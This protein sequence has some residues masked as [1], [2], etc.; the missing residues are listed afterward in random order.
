MK[1]TFR[2]LLLLAFACLGLASLSSPAQAQQSNPVSCQSL[3]STT[4]AEAFFNVVHLIPGLPLPCEDMEAL[5]QG[6]AVIYST[7]RT[8]ELRAIIAEHG[9]TSDRVRRFVD[10]KLSKEGNTFRIITRMGGHVYEAT[11]T[12]GVDM[13]ANITTINVYIIA[14]DSNGQAVTRHTAQGA[15]WQ[16][17]FSTA[18]ASALG[19]TAVNVATLGTQTALQE[20]TGPDCRGN[21][22]PQQVFH[23]AGGTASSAS[24]SD[25]RSAIASNI[26]NVVEI[27]SACGTG[28]SICGAQ[29]YPS[30]HPVGMAPA[31]DNNMALA[32]TGT[33]Y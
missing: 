14:N 15:N 26:A 6:E 32:P 27:G 10:S 19:Q 23:I 28:G 4:G 5:R 30:P 17:T 3:V 2:G 16:S 11:R 13:D 1:K 9:V 21:C 31:N 33:G 7:F 29:P 12:K 8:E 20:L 24:A 18:M 25:S 22:G